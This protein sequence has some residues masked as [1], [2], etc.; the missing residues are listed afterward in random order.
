M[1]NITICPAGISDI[2]VLLDLLYQLG[3]PKPRDDFDLDSFRNLVKNYVTNSDKMIFVAKL[4]DV[5]IIG[6]V[7]VVLLP[8]LNNSSLEMY[9]P[10]LIVIENFQNHG[11][12]KKIMKHCIQF[13]KEKKCHRIRLES[14]I[15]RKN[16]HD[17]YKNL[18]F[19]QSSLSFSKII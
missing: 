17:F 7:S 18:E 8:R 4:N 11:I 2:P 5:E 14:G 3:R 19:E 6:M 16:S 13:A 10:E 15:Q 12:G 1:E 9:I